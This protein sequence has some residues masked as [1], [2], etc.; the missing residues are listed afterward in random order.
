MNQRYILF[1]RAGVFY[2]EDRQTGKQCSLRTR[3]KAEGITL[4]H[5]RNETVRQPACW[6]TTQPD[7]FNQMSRAGKKTADG[8][9]FW[10]LKK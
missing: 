3:D 5:A 6:E 8:L 2:C 4:L 7:H 10:R 1:Q 9:M